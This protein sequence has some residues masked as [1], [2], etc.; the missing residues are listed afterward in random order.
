MTTGKRIVMR[1]ISRVFVLVLGCMAFTGVAFGGATPS[2]TL[3]SSLNPSTYGSSVTFTA[4]VMPPSGTDTGNVSPREVAPTGTVTFMNGSTPLGTATI[5]GGTAIYSTSTLA[6]GSNSITAVYGGDENFNSG[7]SSALAQTVTKATPTVT[8]TSS[9][10]PSTYGSSVTLT[11]TLLPATATGTVTF[12]NGSTTLGT[13]TI[14]GG[15]A[16]Y[17]TSVLA[18]GSHSIT[19]SYGGDTNDN[20][21]KSSALT[22]TVNKATPTVTLTSSL[23]PSTYG[24]SVTFTA[25]LLPATATGTVTFKNGSTTLGTGTI[26]SGSATYSTSTLAVGSNSITASYGGDTND[27]SSTSS[28]LTQTVNQASTTVTLASSANPSIYGSSVTFT[29]TVSPSTATGTVTFTD[30]S[31]TLGDLTGEICTRWNERESTW[32][33]SGSCPSRG[34]SQSRS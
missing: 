20:S 18:V 23:N 24:S 5:S 19:A 27:N 6:A 30:G 2:V 10:N 8:L 17:S 11:A 12:K 21:S 28:A 15:T 16:T 22:Q 33:K 31:T 32:R 9:L 13:G 3:T 1:T 34:T 14:S 25:T 26:S 4:T 7:T 29:A